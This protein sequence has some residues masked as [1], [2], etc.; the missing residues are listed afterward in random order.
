MVQQNII[1]LKGHSEANLWCR[2][3]RKIDAMKYLKKCLLRKPTLK[4]Y[5]PIV[6]VPKRVYCDE[7][8][9]LYLSI[10]ALP[11]NPRESKQDKT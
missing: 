5:K 7:Q 3:F 6:F 10:Y 11:R 4:I 8:C 1:F 2:L 9:P